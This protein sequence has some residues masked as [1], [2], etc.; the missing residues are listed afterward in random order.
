MA[1]VFRM[2]FQAQRLSTVHWYWRAMAESVSPRR[3]VC[4]RF[5][6]AEVVVDDDRAVRGAPDTVRRWP[7]RI[8][9][10]DPIPLSDRSVASEI[11]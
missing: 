11:P 9:D 6:L 3:T 7:V 10:V 1:V 8:V 5:A 2:A 4:V